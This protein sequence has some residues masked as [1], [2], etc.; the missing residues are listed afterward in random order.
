MNFSVA[1]GKTAF[2]FAKDWNCSL[3][4]AENFQKLWYSER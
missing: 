2:G 4:E 1:Y 3:E